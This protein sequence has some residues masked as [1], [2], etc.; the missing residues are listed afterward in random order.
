M[1][2]SSDHFVTVIK[3]GGY[4]L[5]ALEIERE[6]LG[7]DYVAEAIVVGVDDEE[8]GQKVAAAIIIRKGVS[9]QRQIEA[10]NEIDQLTLLC[11]QERAP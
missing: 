11:S 5:S 2:F 3:S 7:L 1:G 10:M 6:I 4:K 9:T 8:Y